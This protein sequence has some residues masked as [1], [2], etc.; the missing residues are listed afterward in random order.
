MPPTRPLKVFLCHAHADRDRVRNLYTR[1]KREGVDVWLDKE[2]LLPGAD[3]E[4]EIRRAV[5]ESDVVVV[6]LS[7]QFNQA[8]FRQKEV[9]LALDTAME[10]PEGEIFIIPARL[11]ECDAPDSLRKWHWVDLFEDDGHEMLMRALRVRAD[12]IGAT[13]RVRRSGKSITSPVNTRGIEETNQPPA[14]M[15]PDTM[16]AQDQDHEKA[17]REA[18]EKTARELAERQA[19]ERLAREKEEKENAEKIEREKAEKENLLLL[20]AARVAAKKLARDAA[21]EKPVAKPVQ[22]SAKKAAANKPFQ[23]WGV[24][25]FILVVFVVIFIAVNQN[26]S[27]PIRSVTSTF[28]ALP[29]A[30]ETFAT[31]PPSTETL[32][33]EPTITPTPTL[34]IGSSTISPKDGMTLLYV[35]AGNFL[36]GSTN[37]DTLASYDEKPQHSVYLDAF[38]IDQTDVTNKMYAACVSAA[39]CTSPSNRSSYT[40]PSYYGNSAFDNYPVIYVSWNDATAYCKW[41]GRQLPSEAQWEKAARGTD[42]RIYPWGNQA[43]S[44]DLLNYNGIVGDTTAV[45]SYPNGASPYGALDMA[46]NVWQWVNDWYSDTYYQSSPA[47]NPLGPNSGQVRVLRGGTWLYGNGSIR[48]ALRVRLNPSNSCSGS[49]FRCARSP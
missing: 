30:T 6:C 3:W 23:I 10:K 13:L 39:G 8:G 27:V 32:T 48:S 11:E 18:A 1:L 49:G 2:K 40:H 9:R 21:Q 7:N 22:P 4:L 43:P 26:P 46:G 28:T 36:M 33:P 29:I 34:G 42:G 12:K 24:L 38:W 25:G 47:S 20:E 35:P 37:Q 5:R 19:A 41:A 45:G 14:N 31:L 16:K 15:V 17:E 44:K